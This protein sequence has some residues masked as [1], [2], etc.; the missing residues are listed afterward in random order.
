M[1][2]APPRLGPRPGAAD[3]GADELAIADR[4]L[5]QWG[6]WQGMNCINLSAVPAG[7]VLGIN[8]A[9]HRTWDL[10]VTDDDYT[11]ID[12]CIARM[13]NRLRAIVV[14]EYAWHGPQPSKWAALGFKRLAYRMALHAAQWNLVAQLGPALDKWRHRSANRRHR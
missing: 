7:N 1:M 9:S 3:D 13:P 8:G 4:L 11:L 14:Y 5:E 6:R 10:T 12:Q 2:D